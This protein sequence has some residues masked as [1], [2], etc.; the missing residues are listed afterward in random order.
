M[1]QT[2]KSSFKTILPNK[3]DLNC[4]LWK[5]EN[6]ALYI[7]CEVDE[8]IP[9]GEYTLSIND[10]NFNYDDKQIFIYFESTGIYL[11]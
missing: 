4:G 10:I 3:Y 5:P 6:K 2:R 11:L 7:F 1:I 8:K 9:K